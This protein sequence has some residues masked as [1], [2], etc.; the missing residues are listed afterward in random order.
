MWNGIESILKKI[1]Q[2][3]V[4]KT[5]CDQKDNGI[6]KRAKIRL[7]STY[8][9]KRVMIV[10]PEELYEIEKYLS[11]M[12]ALK[13]FFEVILNS[14]K[15]SRMFNIVGETWNPITGCLHFCRYCWARQLALTKLKNT[16]RYKD[17]F[18][19]R[20]NE[21]ELRKSFR[22]G[23]VFVS[24]M[25][26]IFSPGVQNEWIV[27]VIKHIAK[28]PDT[29][30]LFLTKNPTK[31]KDLLDIMPPN[32]ILGATIETNKDDLYTEHKISQ[33]PLPSIR[34][35][36]M[37]ELEWPLKFISIEPILDFDLETFVQWIKDINPFM[38]YV[39]YDNY[40]WKLPEPPMKKTQELI[41]RLGKFTLVVKKTI[42][43]AW[44]E[45][46]SIMSY[47]ADT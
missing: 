3:G 8:L 41:E 40:N 15:G 4:L 1:K 46:Q 44:Y 22:G 9:D 16:K 17:G 23:V 21:E 20:L 24:D 43:P 14:K 12:T 35:R 32:A 6:C 7:K 33:A 34:Y 36:A 18:K 42:R 5:T 19:P 11:S 45:K 2:R 28:F 47:T 25:G 13:N 38:V 39:G 10:F 37:K 31:Y 26:D 27:K 30:F 29:Y